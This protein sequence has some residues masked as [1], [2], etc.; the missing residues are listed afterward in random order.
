MSLNCHLKILWRISDFSSKVRIN[1]GIYKVFLSCVYKWYIVRTVCFCLFVC[2]SVF[3][4]FSS[5]SFSQESEIAYPYKEQ[6]MSRS[7]GI[8]AHDDV[9]LRCL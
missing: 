5:S 4:S 9:G 6:R 1:K 2:L 8:E 7:D 3:F